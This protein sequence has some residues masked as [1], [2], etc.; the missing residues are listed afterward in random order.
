ML[1]LLCFAHA[2]LVAAADQGQ[3]EDF[4]IYTEHPRIFLRPQRLKLLRRERERASLRWQNFE[5]MLA[6]NAPLAEPGFARALAYRV[7]GDSRAG[8]QAVEWA[9]GP[10]AD[11][12]QLALVF[13]WCQDLLSETESRALAA[14]LQAG[15]EQSRNDTGVAAVRSRVLAAAAL[16]GHLSDISAAELRNAVQGWWEAR[17]VPAL[18]SGRFAIGSGDACALFEILHVVR[19]NLNTD[20]REA[21]PG[22]FTNLPIDRLSSYYPGV[23]RGPEGEFRI[24]AS[25][26]QGEPDFRAAALARA[27]ELSMVAYETSSPESQTLQGWLMHDRFMMKGAFGAPY[28]F[29]WANP[30]QP[31]LSYYH[32]PLF[33]HDK[34]Y[35]RLFIRSDWEDNAEWL[36]FFDGELQRFRDGK[37]AKIPD[38]ASG[39]APISL[40]G[41]IVLF[42]NGA[43][44]FKVAGN[45]EGEKAFIIGLK[46]ETKFVVKM[47]HNGAIEGRTDPGGILELD[48][49]HRAE[50]G[51]RLREAGK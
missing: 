46:P 40:G 23:F 45:G 35:G 50:T 29:L 22:Y 30:Y 43:G 6:S 33:Y 12:R 28:E 37:A 38:P 39:A 27:A 10:A 15:I 9:L 2:D 51:I 5:A 26:H 11:L 16:A 17:I 31:G 8:R 36:G 14:K 34:E 13:D 4:R 25:H 3:D 32:L 49:P 19:D 41:A 18:K 44:A 24:P 48:L 47:E 20:L 1:G 21:V 7:S 42:E